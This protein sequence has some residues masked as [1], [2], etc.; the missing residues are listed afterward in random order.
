MTGKNHLEGLQETSSEHNWALARAVMLAIGEAM[1]S[2]SSKA[3][4][5][6]FES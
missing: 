5:T 4:L 6:R 2:N 3:E 1:S